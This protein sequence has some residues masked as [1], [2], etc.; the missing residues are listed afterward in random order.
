MRNDIALRKAGSDWRVVSSVQDRGGARERN[1]AREDSTCVASGATVISA[2]GCTMGGAITGGLA[3]CAPVSSA[4]TAQ[5]A[6]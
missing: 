1:A 3:V 6:Q 2:E 5:V 4:M